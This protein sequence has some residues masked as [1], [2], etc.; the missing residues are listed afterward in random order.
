M[1]DTPVD[2]IVLAVVFTGVSLAAWQWQHTLHQ[3]QPSTVVTEHWEQVREL[4]PAPEPFRIPSDTAPETL[5]G[6]VRANP[7]SRERRHIPPPTTEASVNKPAEP[8]PPQFVFKGR[9]VMG[10]KQR[11]I[12]EDRQHNKTYFVQVGQEVVGLTVVE[13]AED[14]I[15]LSDVKTNEQVS[16]SLASKTASESGPPGKPKP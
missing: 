5:Q 4:F 13:I 1:K 14:H 10:T 9:V 16:I 7:F 11:G 6:I 12:L 2:S 8:L 15:V 3:R